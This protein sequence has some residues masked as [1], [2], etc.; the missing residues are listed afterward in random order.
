MFSSLN[1]GQDRGYH[2]GYITL[3]LVCFVSLRLSVG[4]PLSWT[5]I[6]G[7]QRMK[8]TDF[9]DLPFPLAP[10][11]WATFLAFTEI[12]KLLDRLQWNCTDI[13]VHLRINCNNFQSPD[14]SSFLDLMTFS[15]KVRQKWLE[16]DPGRHFL[17]VC[18]Q[19]RPVYH[20]SNEGTAMYPLMNAGFLQMWLKDEI[21]TKIYAF[22]SRGLEWPPALFWLHVYSYLSCMVA[23]FVH[24]GSQRWPT[25]TFFP[26]WQLS[27]S[28]HA[29]AQILHK[30][31]IPA[32]KKKKEPQFI[33]VFIL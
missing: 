13:N 10:L 25:D 6:H 4:S 28:D 30:D 23:L 16:K 33:V 12:S 32:M 29:K 8:P 1:I 9:G 19:P 18:L 7:P 5:N 17:T 31:Q 21:M 20:R 27:M 11:D 2:T 3:S 24:Q 14:E 22:L 15:F 26:P